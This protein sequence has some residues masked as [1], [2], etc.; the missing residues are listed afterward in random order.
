MI[1]VIVTFV[2]GMVLMSLFGALGLMFVFDLFRRRVSDM[3]LV[4]SALAMSAVIG[5]LII[6][7]I[8]APIRA[9]QRMDNSFDA[10][11]GAFQFGALLGLLLGARGTH[12][13]L[14]IVDYNRS[15]R[16][17]L[18]RHRTVG[19]VLGRPQ[20]ML[21]RCGRRECLRLRLPEIAPLTHSRPPC[22]SS[23]AI[24]SNRNTSPR[25]RLWCPR[26]RS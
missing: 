21:L 15:A 16:T 13:H 14:A 17:I 1:V 6:V 23:S 22:E 10:L 20:V 26:L 4:I 9:L 24:P 12:V 19:G 25:S 7:V 2:V 5:G 8:V 11:L 18:D 3:P